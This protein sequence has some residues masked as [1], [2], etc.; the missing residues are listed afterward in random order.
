MVVREPRMRASVD[1][2]GFEMQMSCTCV[3]GAF[4][5]LFSICVATVVLFGSVQAAGQVTFGS[6]TIGDITVEIG[7]R[8]SSRVLPA[9]TG[10]TAPYTYRV[11]ETLPAGL[12]FN[13][14]DRVLSGT[15]TELVTTNSYTYEVADNTSSATISFGITVNGATELRV[16]MTRG[17]Y[18][19]TLNWYG[20]ANA[21]SYCIKHKLAASSTF[22]ACTTTTSNGSEN[23]LTHTI[24]NLTL[25]TQYS[26]FIEAYDSQNSAIDSVTL[27]TSTRADE[28]PQFPSTAHITDIELRA[29]LQ[30]YTVSLPEA[31]GGNGTITYQIE[32][33]LPAGLTLQANRQIVGTPTTPQSSRRYLYK[34]VDA[35]GDSS[36]ALAFNIT[37]LGFLPIPGFR[38]TA[39]DTFITVEWNDVQNATDYTVSH[40]ERGSTTWIEEN[41]SASSPYQISSLTNDQPYVIR[42]AAL[43]GS[44]EFTHA[45]TI[46]TPGATSTIEV[47]ATGGDGEILVSWTA[48]IGA[49]R[50]RIQH[51]LASGTNFSTGEYATSVPA[52][53]FSVSNL[54]LNTRYTVRVEAYGATNTLISSDTDSATTL[55]NT[56]PTFDNTEISPITVYLGRPVDATLP[57]HSSGGNQPFVYTISPRL[58]AGLTFD[59]D[60]R[61]IS[62]TLTS[63]FIASSYSYRV[64]DRHGDT[65]RTSFSFDLRAFF[66]R[67]ASSASVRESNPDFT[68]VNDAFVSDRVIPT[69]STTEPRDVAYRL[70]T[71]SAT[72]FTVT[73]STANHKAPILALAEG[74]TLDFDKGPRTHNISIFATTET[75]NGATITLG[76]Y[77][78]TLRVLNVDEPPQKVDMPKAGAP[79]EELFM[80]TEGIREF[81]LTNRFFDP[82]QLSINID[83]ASLRV[84]NRDASI[85]Y[86]TG[87]SASTISTTDQVVKAEVLNS[88]L[89]RIRVDTSQIRT[90]RSLTND[91][92]VRARDQGNLQ[93]EEFI[94]RVNVKIGANNPPSFISGA[95]AVSSTV[96]E[97]TAYIGT[98]YATDLDDHARS[99]GTHNDTLTFSIQ[100]ASRQP[101]WD[102]DVLL[103]NGACLYVNTTRDDPTD[104]WVATVRSVVPTT[105]TPQCRKGFDFEE[106]IS[107]RFV[108]EVSDGFGGEASVVV[109]IFVEDVNEPASHDVS[110]L[111]KFQLR[112]GGSRSVDLNNFI[113][114]PESAALEF[115][116]NTFNANVA[117]VEESEGVLTVTAVGAGRTNVSVTYTDTGKNTGSF[118]LT[119]QVKQSENNHPPEFVSE[120]ST[121]GYE[122]DENS[123]GGTGIGVR[124]IATDRDSDDELT[125]TIDTYNDVFNVSSEQGSEGQLSL[126]PEATLNFEAKSKYN[127]T[128]TVDDGWGGSDTLGITIT[129]NDVNEPPKLNPANTSN[130][131]ADEV[132]VSMG[133]DFTYDLTQHFIDEDAVDE[134]RLRYRVAIKNRLIASVQ[135]TSKGQMLVEG[136][137]IGSSDVTVTVTDS[138]SNSVTLLFTLSIVD[139]ATPVVRNPIPDQSLAVGE[140]VDIPLAN[141][142][143]DPD[144]DVSVIKAEESD[145]TIVLAILTKNKTEL[146]LFGYSVGVSDVTVTAQ[147]SAG[148]EVEDEF[149]A[150]ITESTASGGPRLARRIGDQTIT[151]G[152]ER[153]VDLSE[154][155]DFGAESELYEI[156]VHSGDA[157]IAN[158]AVDLLSMELS[159]TGHTPGNAYLS[160]LA[161]ATDGTRMGDLFTTYVETMPEVVATLADVELEVGGHSHSVDFGHVFVDRDGDDL[162]YSVE[163]TNPLYVDLDWTGTTLQLLPIRRGDTTVVVTAT[164]PKG[165][166]ATLTLGVSVGNEALRTAAEKSL[167]NYGRTLLSSV[168]AAIDT[169]VSV[170]EQASAKSV[171][172]WLESLIQQENT[173]MPPGLPTRSMWNEETAGA[174]GWKNTPVHE[175]RSPRSF[176]LGFGGEQSSWSLWSFN[177]Q[178]HLESDTA[179]VQSRSQ[180]LGVDI[181][182]N[183]RWMLGV[184][185]AQSQGETGFQYGNAARD[186]TIQSSMVI[187]YAS[188]DISSSRRVWSMIGKGHGSIEVVDAERAE[189]TPLTSDF[190]LIGGR[191]ALAQYRNLDFA[192]R[193]DYAKL[194]L[195]SSD[196]NGSATGL[197]SSIERTRI[198]IETGA[199][200]HTRL[201]SLSP[202]VD[203][204]LRY[205]GGADNIGSGVEVSVGLNWQLKGFVIETKTRGVKTG[206]SVQSSTSMSFGMKPDSHGK[207]LTLKFE[208]RWGS[209]S[210]SNNLT[211]ANGYDF[212]KASG[213]LLGSDSS[214]AI[215]SEVGYGVRVQRDT[216]L[217]QPFVRYEED[218]N[219]KL[220]LIGAQLSRK[221]DVNHALQVELA[222]GANTDRRASSTG[223]VLSARA[224]FKF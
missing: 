126:K 26:V 205:E 195:S 180:F 155:F 158:G 37:V 114:D 17:D 85:V 207:G 55:G 187:P 179:Q 100:G 132:S 163:V 141:V 121:V 166:T 39:G 98:F 101:F 48:V 130:G 123:P 67:V 185:V 122:V 41:V 188:Y 57:A 175:F 192:V 143:H 77:R 104:R 144:G 214:R 81:V 62:G 69:G 56:S 213:S 88:V 201:G 218:H 118:Q 193:G 219:Y 10:G 124:N 35:D 134:G 102:E 112:V 153:V 95:T 82:E 74:K 206:T 178:Q 216:A 147:D 224:S 4:R 111:P 146:T 162:D 8:I 137:R 66:S 215:T 76:V 63:S 125:Y 120:V 46:A 14:S 6:A 22:S 60:T 168:S 148:G 12:T 93:S 18:S 84:T 211:F 79:D 182:A 91:V 159:L 36:S 27:Q 89:L 108:L 176:A 191:Q 145:D 45:E 196:G 53:G 78:L 181:K 3:F 49:Q 34:A 177:D 139:K 5:R 220:G 54:E 86:A 13:A 150:T 222:I 199:T 7:Q 171:S 99:N 109:S 183:D 44:V 42:V 167:T 94:V 164:D 119:V 221:L 58:P 24:D 140:F 9:A 25:D 174:F 170:D 65:A 23:L 117:T 38:T 212:H 29:G 107:P 61:T 202:A 200:F 156:S 83:A 43:D 72:T 28:T 208:P 194:M 173:G 128:L 149:V 92:R 80:V 223:S 186:M 30:V 138:A 129:V 116:V 75:T 31:R 40:R 106:Q 189:S 51:R 154:I 169:R 151:A 59:S 68:A 217:L 161:T 198:G 87:S 19:L 160:V 97:N 90:A 21:D 204:G 135:S 110:R 210:S 2:G 70:D 32:P 105:A 20:L 15:P 16:S 131:R 52:G 133:A 96:S 127:F 136:R 50:Y 11:V 142:F 203:V 71:Q 197:E 152:V 64:R 172:S 190:W 209:L 157:S 33:T 115:I 47:T 113:T 1:P 184:A 73:A 165:R 103:L